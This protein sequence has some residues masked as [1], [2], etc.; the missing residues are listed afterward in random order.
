MSQPIIGHDFLKFFKLLVDPCNNQLLDAT[1]LQPLTTTH[2]GTPQPTISTIT[3]PVQSLLNHFPSITASELSSPNPTHGITHTIP[4]TSQQPIAAKPLHL[5][6]HKHD[7]ALKEFLKLE[8]QGIIRRSNSPWASPLHMVP[9]KNGDW[10]PCVDYRRLNAAMTHDSYPLLQ[11]FTSRLHNC[12]V[13][14]TIVLIKGYHQIPMHKDDIQKT[15]IITPFGLFEFLFMPF[16]LRNAGQAFQRL[17]DRL[18]AHLPFVFVYLDDLII[19]SLDMDTHLKHMEQVFAILGENNL[20]INPEK[21]HF[22]QAPVTFL[23]HTITASGI[24]PLNTHVTAIANFPQPTTIKQ[25]QRFLGL[26]NF[27]PSFLPNIAAPLLPHTT[28][29]KGKPKTLTWTPDMHTAFT[30]AKTLLTHATPLQFPNPH[31]AIALSTDAS[32][33]QVGAVLQQQTGSSWKPLAFFSAQLTPTQ[34]RYSTFDRELLAVYLATRHFRFLLEGRKFHIN[35][36]HKPLITAI[37]RPSPPWTAH[38]QRHFSYISEFTTDL[39]H[40]AGKHNIVADTLSRSHIAATLPD[41]PPP[42]PIDFALLAQAQ[43]TDPTIQQLKQSPS[44]QIVTQTINNTPMM[45][46]SQQKLFVHWFPHHSKKPFLS[47]FTTLVMLAFAPPAAPQGHTHIFTIIDRTTRWPEA[48]PLKSTT[49]AYCANPLF[50]HWI[51]RFGV[52]TTITSD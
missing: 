13:F 36:D 49:A 6:A 11:D 2:S 40:I 27:Y 4:T 52:P 42:P 8:S 29:L 14:S 32:D 12:T 20:R 25:L 43:L 45:G 21:C 33:K 51:I 15:A 50:H 38:Q 5:D 44:L 24:T 41:T 30:H 28:A 37:H 9:K 23:G 48:I 16:G 1:D 19:A 3:S 22:T 26:L 34:Q 35:T 18:F 7:I 31:A 17:M 46:R 47:I 10:R 39:R